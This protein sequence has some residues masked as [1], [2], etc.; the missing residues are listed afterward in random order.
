MR[1]LPKAKGN[2]LIYMETIGLLPTIV[3]TLT[4]FQDQMSHGK[5]Q[6]SL[7]ALQ[8]EISAMHCEPEPANVDGGG[9]NVSAASRNT[10][11]ALTSTQVEAGC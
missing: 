7:R 5:W 6:S 9:R 4:M 8:G 10:E 1:R 11:D 2:G 3:S